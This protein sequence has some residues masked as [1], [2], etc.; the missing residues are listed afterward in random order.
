MQYI[1]EIWPIISAYFLTKN[2]KYDIYL[3]PIV[4]GIYLYFSAYKT[5]ILES[6]TIGILVTD[7]SS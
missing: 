2:I 6:A 5:Y 4:I 7:I 3:Q 1:L